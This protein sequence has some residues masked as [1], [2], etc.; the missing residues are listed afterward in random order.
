MIQTLQRL[1]AK[2][3]F[4]IIELV[5]VMAILGVMMAIIFPF[6]TNKKARIDE[7]NATAKDYYSALQSIMIKYSLYE[8]PL[9]P[10]YSV[11][12]DLGDMRYYEKLGGNYPYKAGTTAGDAPATTS[13]YIAFEVDNGE[14]EDIVTYAAVESDTNYANG[15]GMYTAACKTSGTVNNEFGKL[16]KAEL[17]GRVSY[18]D[19][20]Y[21]ANVTYKQIL[22][23]T[24]PAKME[25][26][27]VK[28]LYTGYSREPLPDGTGKAFT[29][30]KNENLYFGDDANVLVN[31]EVF[32]VCAEYKGTSTVGQP[33][34]FLY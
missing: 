34:T 32:G 9:S 10:Q 2:K 21:Y 24:I 13:L 27:T 4:T 12:P 30:Y 29:T 28:V 17:K 33:G 5:V 8:G 16:L 22:T 20:F 1:K 14:I 3:G 11:N 18:H 31:G 26:E 6:I 15:V 23:G 19:G 25:A 7:A